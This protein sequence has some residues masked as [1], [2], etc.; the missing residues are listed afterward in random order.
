MHLYSSKGEE[1]ASD[2]MWGRTSNFECLLHIPTK[3]LVKMVHTM[4]EHATNM[5]K[6]RKKH[7]II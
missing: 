5:N 4:E 7:T 1:G 2:F 3:T 6:S